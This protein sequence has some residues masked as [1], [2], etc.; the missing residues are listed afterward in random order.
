MLS[1]DTG[2][3]DVSEKG[4]YVHLI[5]MLIFLASVETFISYWYHEVPFT[6]ERILYRESSL[7]NIIV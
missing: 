7:T 2:Q 6:L 3:T 4:W 5:V 1:T